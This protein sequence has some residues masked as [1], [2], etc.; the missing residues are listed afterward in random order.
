MASMCWVTRR[1]PI[2]LRGLRNNTDRGITDSIITDSIIT[3]GIG[4]NSS[5]I[6]KLLRLINL[7]KVQ[8]TFPENN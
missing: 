5:L 2:D 8:K 7:K 3:D 1:Q 6:N 4:T